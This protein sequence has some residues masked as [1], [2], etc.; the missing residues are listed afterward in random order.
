MPDY[1]PIL[2][3]TMALYLAAQEAAQ[4]AEVEEAEVE[5]VDEVT[6][7]LPVDAAEPTE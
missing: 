3:K 6:H 2:P 7:D 5:E 1:V 4:Q